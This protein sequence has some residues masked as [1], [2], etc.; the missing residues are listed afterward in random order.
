MFVTKKNKLISVIDRVDGKLTVVRKTPQELCNV[1]KYEV[2]YQSADGSKLYRPE[3]IMAGCCM[4]NIDKTWITTL[5]TDF[6]HMT[7]P[8]FQDLITCASSD[9]ETCEHIGPNHDLH[10]EMIRKILANY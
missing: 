10:V 8:E 4:S 2:P 3:L 5:S 6:K 9:H 1:S 7:R